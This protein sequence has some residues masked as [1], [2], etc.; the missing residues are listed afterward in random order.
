MTPVFF[1]LTVPPP[2]EWPVT[3][4]ELEQTLSEANSDYQAL[5][6]EG[7][8]EATDRADKQLPCVT[9]VLPRGVAAELHRTLGMRAVGERDKAAGGW[10]AAARSIEPSHTLPRELV[11]MGHPV[12]LAY[13]EVDLSTGTF[14]GLGAPHGD[15]WFDGRRTTRRPNNWPTIVQWTTP[16]GGVRWTV[17]LEPGAS[18]PTYLPRQEPELVQ[19]APPMPDPSD[20]LTS[21]AELPPLPIPPTRSARGPLLGGAALALA[22]TGVLYGIAGV[23]EL[24]YNDP[25]TP[26]EDLHGLRARTNSLVIASAFTGA[27]TIGL[28]IAGLTAPPGP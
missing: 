8:L 28:T 12:R 25:T 13:G 9:E 16:D 22:A 7:F 15:L 5:D 18:V 1:A 21:A 24:Q 3:A 6:I 4:A 2:C 27:A 20:P 11:P 19:P 23:S 17:R 14:S 26:D 10:F